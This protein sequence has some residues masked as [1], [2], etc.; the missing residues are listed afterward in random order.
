MTFTFEEL[1][2]YLGLCTLISFWGGFVFSAWV[3]KDFYRKV[4]EK[5]VEA[6]REQYLKVLKKFGIEFDNGKWVRNESREIT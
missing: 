5:N 4:L 6:Y 3:L 1:K 2:F